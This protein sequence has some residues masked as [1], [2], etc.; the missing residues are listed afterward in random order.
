MNKITMPKAGQSMEEGTIVRWLKAEGE[1]VAKGEILLEIETDKAT[2]EVEATDEGVL[3]TILVAA[4]ETAP[5]LAPIALLG[6]AGESV[7]AVVAEAQAELAGARGVSTAEVAGAS[8]ADQ[9]ATASK[10]GETT[11]PAGTPA[12]QDSVVAGAVV[13]ILMPKAGQSMEEGTIVKWRVKPGEVINK[14]DIIFEVE[15]DKA[16]VEVEATDAGRLARI[17][18]GEGDVLPVLAPVAYLAAS[19]AD[20]D[21]WLAAGGGAIAEAQEPRSTGVPAGASTKTAKTAPIAETPAPVATFASGGTPALRGATGRVKASPAARKLAGERGVDLAAL[22]PGSG[23]GGRIL[24]TD[25]AQAPAAGRAA[26]PA[27]APAKAKTAPA[28]AEIAPLPARAAGPIPPPQRRALSGMRKAIARNLVASKQT[29][30]HYYMRLTIDADPLFTFHRAEKTG[31]PVSVNDLIV[32]ACARVIMEFPAFRSRLE[33]D[34]LVEY[35]SANIGVAVGLENG[36]VVP[37]VVAADRLTLKDLAAE[38]RRLVERARAGKVENMGQGVFTISNLGMF[39]VEEF[40]AIINPPEAAILA[41]SAV[42][43]T[44][45]VKDGMMRPGRVM[46]MTLSLDHRIIDGLLAA[47]YAARLKQVL[48][49][50]ELLA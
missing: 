18:A 22:G 30:P 15:T 23:P 29:I 31:Y 25:V 49:A 1:A 40:S 5:V 19:D 44:V 46:T 34:E 16:V 3:R 35:A 6:T 17:V 4:G 48:E 37:V 32:S 41:V 14:G 42:R 24:S 45:I 39:G 20:V 43:E 26:A 27:V 33:K 28:A 50:P 10:P 2:I 13:P 7:D 47:K 21:A 36:L 12:L 11:A 9:P 38:T 8:A